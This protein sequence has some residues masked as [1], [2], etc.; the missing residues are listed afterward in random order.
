MGTPVGKNDLVSSTNVFKNKEGE[1]GWERGG[2]GGERGGGG[3][4]TGIGKRDQ[5][6]FSVNEE[7]VNILYFVGHN[8]LTP[9]V[10]VE[11]SHMKL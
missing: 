8:H 9:L 4:G 1:G 7:M 11:R 6:T 2:G 5:E 3:G 10:Y